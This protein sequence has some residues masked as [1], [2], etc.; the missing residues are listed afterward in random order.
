MIYSKL[1][2][3]I[4]ISHYLIKNCSLILS[5]FNYPYHLTESM[6]KYSLNL[7][8]KNRFLFTHI[9]ISWICKGGFTSFKCLFK[10]F[11]WTT[12]LMSEKKKKFSPCLLQEKVWQLNWDPILQHCL[13]PSCAI[14]LFCKGILSWGYHISRHCFTA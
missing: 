13:C 2:I 8:V 7:N 14:N 4:L 1:M 5:V 11:Q 10:I 3:K 12:S 6:L 9:C